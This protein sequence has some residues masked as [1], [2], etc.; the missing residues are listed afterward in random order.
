M[1]TR[2]AVDFL[3]VACCAFER[4]PRPWVC[5]TRVHF[6]SSN[7]FPL[8]CARKLEKLKKKEEIVDMEDFDTKWFVRDNSTLRFAT[9]WRPKKTVMKNGPGFKLAIQA[10][11]VITPPG[12]GHA[13]W[14]FWSGGGNHQSQSPG[15][16]L[17]LT[18]LHESFSR[19]SCTP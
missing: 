5:P 15:A 7:G 6:I 12:L 8:N 3:L 16:I 18:Y 17:H 19:V 13:G 14:R 1:R 10:I 9:R 11:R 2:T 4:G